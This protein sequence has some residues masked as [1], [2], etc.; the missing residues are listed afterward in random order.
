[1]RKFLFKMTKHIS[2]QNCLNKACRNYGKNDGVVLHD[3]KPSRLRCRSC[4]KTWSI[5]H[6]EFYFGL[7]AN[8]VKI[9]RAVDMLK[10][11]I[12]IRKIARLIDVSSGTVMRWKK[13]LND[14]INN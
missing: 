1:M 11:G 9:R 4:N 12:P 5:H 6:Q 14:L 13:K 10:A 3:K 8:P 7:R 2:Q